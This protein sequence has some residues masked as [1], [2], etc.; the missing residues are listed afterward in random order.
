MQLRLLF[1]LFSTLF[2]ISVQ[3]QFYTISS[4]TSTVEFL[5][6]YKDSDYSY[7]KDTSKVKDYVSE[8]TDSTRI[9]DQPKGIEIYIEKDIPVFVNSTDSLLLGLIHDRMNV[10]LPLNFLKI[11]S[12]YGYRR[13]PINKC[14]KFHDGIDLKCDGDF[15]YSMLPGIV[16]EVRIGNK[17]YGN[18]IIIDHGNIQ[19]LYAHLK[20]IAV[21]KNDV[22]SAGTIVAL[23]GNTGKSTGPHL[24]IKI[25]K[26][27]KS[28]NPDTFIS[29][30]NNYITSLQDKIA[31]IKFG[32][33]PD[34]ELTIDNLHR[35]LEKYSVKYPKIVIAQALL[36][37]GY[38]T[39]NVCLNYNNLFGLRRPSD[40]S[41]YTFDNWEESVKAY[42]DY[43]Q[44][45]YKGGDYFSFLK[46][47]GY[48]EDK[49]YVSKVRSIV[50]SL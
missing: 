33:K 6:G 34:M 48:A 20:M 25:M 17:G 31:Y 44:Y 43:V 24:H 8:T 7:V 14:K 46:R 18:Y 23:S 38:F 21:R 12:A 3:A 1:I 50:N 47:I 10:C 41:Y 45:K 37:T 13:D 29:Y 5:N 28:V 27:G 2:Q 4:D 36:E 9:F 16:K 30:L 15:V 39:S 49:Q 40:G 26:N 22:I 19:C 11:S 35:A 42:R 32:T